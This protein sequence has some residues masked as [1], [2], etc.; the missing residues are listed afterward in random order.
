MQWTAILSLQVTSDGVIATDDT[1]YDA[2]GVPAR[3][4]VTV[5]FE[6]YLTVGDTETQLTLPTYDEDTVSSITI[7]LSQDGKLRVV[8]TASDGVD[9]NEDEEIIVAYQH[10]LECLEEKRTDFFNNCCEDVTVCEISPIMKLTLAI[11]QIQDDNANELYDNAL[12]ILNGAAVLCQ[13]D[14]CDPC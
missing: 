4:T 10:L 14:N 13:D 11:E 5:N 2:G 12:C 6:A 1:V 7:D 8:M 3:N 9:D